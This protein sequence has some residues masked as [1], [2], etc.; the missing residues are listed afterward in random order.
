MGAI[1]FTLN[2]SP[3]DAEIGD[4]STLLWSATF[5]DM[6]VRQIV[7]DSAGNAYMQG[8]CPYNRSGAVFVCPTVNP[9]TSGRPQSQGDVGAYVLKV[10][11]SGSLLFSPILNAGIGLVGLRITSHFSKA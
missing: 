7:V 5:G 6:R 2:G 11:P 4:G 1:R 10:S 8:T 9:L 3:Q